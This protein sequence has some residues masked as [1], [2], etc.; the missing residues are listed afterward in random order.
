MAPINGNEVI[1][2]IKRQKDSMPKGYG[3][4]TDPKT[5]RI[6]ASAFSPEQNATQEN[7]AWGNQLMQQPE[8]TLSPEAKAI[9]AEEE[10]LGGEGS[11]GPS[12][13]PTQDERYSGM[14]EQELSA[15][16]EE[17]LHDAG[18]ISNWMSKYGQSLDDVYNGLGEDVTKK[19]M[20][21]FKDARNIKTEE[22]AIRLG[23]LNDMW[24]DM[25]EIDAQK[26]YQEGVL[27]ECG[28]ECQE[29][30]QMG[31]AQAADWDEDMIENN[32]QPLSIPDKEFEEKYAA[33]LG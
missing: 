20:D 19:D 15:N 21:L 24:M 16:R 5:G 31:N 18:N 11:Y 10:Y 25:N 9:Y 3:E 26:Y 14:D 28:G 8:P 27:E 1:R 30:R 23:E 29:R 13:T 4:I 6:L 7:V 33:L 22:D 17:Y 2:D 12:Y 32:K